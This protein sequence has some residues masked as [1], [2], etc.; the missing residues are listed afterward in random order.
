ME[1]IPSSQFIPWFRSVAPYIHAHKGKTFVIGI[2]GELIAA[3]KLNAFIQDLALIHSLNIKIVLVHGFRTQIEELLHVKGIESHFVQGVRVTDE[4]ALACAQEAAGRLRYQIEATFSQGLPNTPMAHAKIRVVS[5]NFIT[6]KPLGIVN[7]VDFKH[8]GLVRKLD[9]DGIQQE[10]SQNNIVLLSPFGYSF[11]G[12]AFTLTMEDIATHTALKLKADKLIFI[13]ESEGVSK[14]AS[15]ETPPPPSIEHELSL[16][17]AQAIFQDNQNKATSSS[18]QVDYLSYAIQAVKGG[19]ERA[20]I[21]PYRID[22]AILQDLFTHHGLG[23]MI[24]DKQLDSLR[25]STIEDVPAIIQLIEPLEQAG[26]MIKRNRSDIESDINA[27][28]VI[29]HDGVL[30]GCAAFYPYPEAQT[31]ELAALAIMQQVQQ[32]GYGDLL[33]KKFEE[34]AS[35]LGFKS[36]FVLTTQTM[37]WFI[38]RGFKSVE[39]TWLPEEKLKKYNW[40]RRSQVLVKQLKPFA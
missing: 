13:G 40:E 11:T 8:T 30:F 19:V 10:L 32:H 36:I 28:T 12:E 17:Q 3:G 18:T 21:L 6:A 34:R 37:H 38:D 1:S 5:G 4:A 9:S 31:A 20:H 33:L 25:P 35:S 15:Q 22:G 29:E 26:I 24:V 7:G 16:Q 2:T 14:Y 39:P 27:Y 23:T